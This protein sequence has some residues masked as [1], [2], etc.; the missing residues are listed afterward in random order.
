MTEKP[1]PR[2]LGV[3]LARGGS[4]GV[5]KKNIRPLAGIPMIAYSIAEAKRSR[6]IQRF[7][8]S[9]DDP[10]IQKVA[11]EYGAE[12]PFLR[13]AHLANDKTPS[14]PALQHAVD[15]AEEDEGRDY[16]YIAELVCTN[17]MKLAEDIDGAI[18]KLIATGAESV[19]GMTRIEDHHPA[20]VKKIVN[21][22]IVDFCMP[23]PHIPRQDIRPEAYI[24]NGS[25]YTMRRDV[26][27][28]RGARY[29]TED[30]R[31][32]MMPLERSVNV[33]TVLDFYLAEILL[34]Q[35]PR[36]YI[37]PVK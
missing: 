21:D 9:T 5:P 28:V 10:E 34:T 31:P 27:M 11:I 35:N 23:E 7:I 24:R 25:I 16:D 17:P 6:Y 4:K 32:Y 19:I 36:T 30:S 20:R 29:D 37:K 12:A 22:R 14:L 3:T 15:W 2:V 18:E 8:V 33:D 13:P 1:L 26:L